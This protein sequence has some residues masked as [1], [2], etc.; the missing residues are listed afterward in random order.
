MASHHVLLLGGHG[1]ISQMLTP[2]L[3]QRSWTVTSVIRAQ[4]QVPAIEKL[5]KGL[6]GTLNVLVHSIEDVASQEQAAGILGKVKPDYIAWS[7]GT[8]SHAIDCLRAFKC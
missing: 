2:L 5:G 6:P 8:C 4:E 1:K 7:A 3:L